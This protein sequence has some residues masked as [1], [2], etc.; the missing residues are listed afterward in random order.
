MY[1]IMVII[2]AKIIA[3]KIEDGAL[4]Q[5]TK[6][7]ME[8][9]LD[10]EYHENKL[11][12]IVGP[13]I[14]LLE[15]G[16]YDHKDKVNLNIVYYKNPAVKPHVIFAH[17][18]AGNVKGR[19]N[20]I[21]KLANYAN[22]VMFDY[23]GYGKST[24][25]PTVRGLYRDIY[26]VWRFLVYKM[27]VSPADICL[28][29]NSLGAALVAWLGRKLYRTN[30]RPKSI[31]MQSG[32]SSFSDIAKDMVPGAAYVVRNTL[33][34]TMCVHD[35]GNRIPILLM[36]S[37]DDKMISISHMTRLLAAN[38]YIRYH[39][40]RGSHNNPRIGE[41]GERMLLNFVV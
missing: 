29:G 34:S 40:M 10:L 35:I 3:N 19:I 31:I 7:P 21:Y 33:N 39:V 28:Y 23:R 37:Q 18:N 8:E 38:N 16:L 6:I 2:T 26:N 4:F 9:S 20:K 25:K 5:P 15:Y 13:N 1:L 12:G 30:L 32:F 27:G 11:K 14:Q 17:G 36:H 41:D 22:Y 24:G